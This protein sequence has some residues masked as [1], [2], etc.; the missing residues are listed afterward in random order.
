MALGSQ[1]VNS[2]LPEPITKSTLKHKKGV[3]TGDRNH[4]IAC[5]FYFHFTIIGLRYERC[6]TQMNKEFF[7]CELRLAQIIMQ[8]GDSLEALKQQNADRK[9]LAKI[10]PHYNWN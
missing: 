5:R 2:V 4:A 9:A 8:Q 3:F 6:L 1:F 7:L 10:Y